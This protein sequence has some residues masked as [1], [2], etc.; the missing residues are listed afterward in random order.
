MKKVYMPSM[1]S[2]YQMQDMGANVYRYLVIKNIESIICNGVGSSRGILSKYILDEIAGMK[3]YQD[4]VK[5]ICLLYPEEL[6]NLRY[7]SENGFSKDLELFSEDVG[8]CMQLL[9]NSTNDLHSNL[10]YLSY[11][12]SS[13]AG[14]ALILN[15]V[16]ALLRAELTKNPRYRFEYLSDRKNNTLLDDIFDGKIGDNELMLLRGN[17]RDEAVDSLIMIEP[18]YAVSLPDDYLSG[19]RESRKRENLL[20]YSM[21]EQVNRYRI[22]KYIGTEYFGKD[23]LTSPD[24]E[25]KK[26][27][28]NI[29]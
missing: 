7:L 12:S 3:E 11:F 1:E 9:N 28:K 10:N 4:M 2:L 23:I 27:I 24:S 14:N 21:N 18:A 29:K 16:L 8:F 13:V 17:L 19:Y 6:E 20:H 26:L 22:N 25:V 5:A 15:K